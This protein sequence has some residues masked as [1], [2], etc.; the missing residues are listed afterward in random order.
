MGMWIGRWLDGGSIPVYRT[1]ASRVTKG[2]SLGALPRSLDDFLFLV[3]TFGPFLFYFSFWTRTIFRY[4]TARGPC[5]TFHRV[6]C[7]L[8][9]HILLRRFA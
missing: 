9:D 2:F 5:I 4:V 6:P 8:Q 1:R 7:L 3:F